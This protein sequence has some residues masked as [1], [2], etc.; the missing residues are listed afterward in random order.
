MKE[1]AQTL[2][3][4]STEAERKMWSIVRN[5]KFFNFRFHRQHRIGYYIVDFV[6]LK[7]KLIIELDG[8]EHRYQVEYDVIRDDY[9]NAAG[10]KVL[11]FWNY[12]VMKNIESVLSII[13]KALTPDPSPAQGRGRGEKKP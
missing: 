8:N 9:L 5:R 7:K 3:K 6:C 13:F 10:F 12:E 4:N 1:R 2:R 11:R